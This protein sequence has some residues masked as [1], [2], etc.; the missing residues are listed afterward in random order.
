MMVID[1]CEDEVYLEH[2]PRVLADMLGGEIAGEGHRL[3][4][5]FHD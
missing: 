4:V 1:E 3:L 5:E 2:L